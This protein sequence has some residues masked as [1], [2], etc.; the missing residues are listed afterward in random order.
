[1]SLYVR[2]SGNCYPGI[3]SGCLKIAHFFQQNIEVWCYSNPK[4]GETAVSEKLITVLTAI[5]LVGFGTLALA[6][7]SG[8][9]AYQGW[10]HQ[11]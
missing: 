1:M 7:W 9:Y 4:K 5:A 2:N 8:G 6:H 10:M 3:Q 11:G